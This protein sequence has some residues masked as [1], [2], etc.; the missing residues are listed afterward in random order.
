[1][2]L[3]SIAAWA[4]RNRT[5]VLIAAVLLPRLAWF[6]ILG[7][8]LPTPDRDQRFYLRLADSFAAGEGLSFSEETARYK[9]LFR[10]DTFVAEN[11]SGESGYLFGTVPAGEPTAAV[12]PGYPVLVGLLFLLTGPVTGTIFM[13]NC[14]AALVGVLAVWK[15][16]SGGWG[17]AAGMAAAVLW[18]VYP[19]F[20]S[21]RPTP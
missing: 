13:I 19:Y 5:A 9:S 2:T 12:E 1:M 15:L 14:A 11:W 18:A 21:T 17:D 8:A 20:V 7:G 10:E 6:A 4:L 16:V 3:R